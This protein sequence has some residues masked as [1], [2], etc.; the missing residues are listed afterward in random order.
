MLA[1]QAGA[2]RLALKSLSKYAETAE[3]MKNSIFK[4]FLHTSSNFGIEIPQILCRLSCL[5][6]S[7][8]KQL[9]TVSGGL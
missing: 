3:H 5:G 2:T 9:A 7:S 6:L 8:F 1:Y 4:K